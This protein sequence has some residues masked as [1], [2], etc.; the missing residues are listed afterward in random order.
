MSSWPSRQREQERSG[1][2]ALD[3]ERGWVGEEIEK[4]Q[5]KK[6]DGK[7]RVKRK[8]RVREKNKQRD[9]GKNERKIGILQDR[10]KRNK[11]NGKRKINKMSDKCQVYPAAKPKN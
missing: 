5:K 10:Q 8:S 4:D 11:R 7:R 1:G 6:W 9:T 3:N 2:E